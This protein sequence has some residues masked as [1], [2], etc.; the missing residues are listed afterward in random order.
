MTKAVFY[1]HSGAY[2]GFRVCGHSGYA[3]KGQ[4]IVCAAVSSACE[5]SLNILDTLG[6]SRFSYKIEE[7]GAVISASLEKMEGELGRACQTVF[8]A[9]ENK[10]TMLA[11]AYPQ[12]VTVQTSEV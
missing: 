12:Y 4:D 11:E 9:F 7:E 5:M 8:L 2:T 3:K 6:A 10:L 1:T